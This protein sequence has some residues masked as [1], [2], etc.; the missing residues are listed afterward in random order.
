MDVFDYMNET[1]YNY[2]Y[3]LDLDECKMH[4]MKIFNENL[5]KHLFSNK[6]LLNEY[7][8][9]MFSLIG[10]IVIFFITTLVLKQVKQFIFYLPSIFVFLFVLI[11]VSLAG[12]LALMLS[13]KIFSYC[14]KKSECHN[15]SS[16]PTLEK[17]KNA[18]KQKD[19][20]N[21]VKLWKHFNHNH[22]NNSIVL[23]QEQKDI[24]LLRKLDA[25]LVRFI[26]NADDITIK[27]FNL[28][29]FESYKQLYMKYIANEQKEE[30]LNKIQKLIGHHGSNQESHL[31]QQLHLLKNEVEECDTDTA[32]YFEFKKWHKDTLDML[33]LDKDNDMVKNNYQNIIQEINNNKED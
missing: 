4:E 1:I 2:F 21:L 13:N 30:I 20:V 24:E 6:L 16:N 15:K 11:M 12:V 25:D 14:Y 32:D 28:D 22:P 17:L 26:E 27:L 19:R 33:K 10:I 5:E 8:A 31:V 29:D 18:T 23:T 9:F 3:F 7:L